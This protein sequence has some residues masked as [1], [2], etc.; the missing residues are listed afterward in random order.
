M[1]NKKKTIL[2]AGI[3]LLVI[4]VSVYF[5]LDRNQ[6]R[7]EK[8]EFVH[9]FVD[10]E[11]KIIGTMYGE[12]VAENIYSNFYILDKQGSYL[13]EATDGILKNL[14]GVEADFSGSEYLGMEV[15]LLKDD[16]IVL[17]G[18]DEN[19]NVSDNFNLVWNPE[20]KF[21]EIPLTP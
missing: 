18:K 4:F 16:Y 3:F 13:Y 1:I 6:T 11:G 5:V 2:I 17:M 20:E 10:K 12:K 8:Y 9:E 14:D 21:F 15:L 7:I 19:G